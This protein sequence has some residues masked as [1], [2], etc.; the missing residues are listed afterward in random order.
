MR[1]KVGITATK[2]TLSSFSFTWSDS[3]PNDCLQTIFSHRHDVYI[4]FVDLYLDLRLLKVRTTM[5]TLVLQFH[6]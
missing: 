6:A 1:E 5:T 4:A 2:Y 3:L